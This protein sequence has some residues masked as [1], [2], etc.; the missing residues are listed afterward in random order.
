[1]WLCHFLMRNSES[2]YCN[3]FSL[4]YLKWAF[5]FKQA[6]LWFHSPKG[7]HPC[8]YVP[9]TLCSWGFNWRWI[10]LCAYVWECVC[11]A[12]RLLIQKMHLLPLIS[13]SGNKTGRGHDGE[14]SLCYTVVYRGSWEVKA[15]VN[16]S[17]FCMHFW[18]CFYAKP[19]YHIAFNLGLCI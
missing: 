2:F 4:N 12:P 11:V 8:C 15:T 7:R 13:I 16:W 5:F 6:P 18:K 3:C 1:M 10:V 19:P 17:R 9:D 14:V